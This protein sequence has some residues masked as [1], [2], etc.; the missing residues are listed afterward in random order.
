MNIFNYFVNLELKN[1][2]KSIKMN[3]IKNTI[4]GRINHLPQDQPELRPTI[5]LPPKSCTLKTD[6]EKILR[7]Q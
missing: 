4:F 3:D 7:P 6:L 1:S 2:E 5:K